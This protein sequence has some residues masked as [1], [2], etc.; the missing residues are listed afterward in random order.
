M[1][2]IARAGGLFSFLLKLFFFQLGCMDV[3]MLLC[4]SFFAPS[5]SLGVGFDF[6]CALHFVPPP[7]PPSSLPRG[8]SINSPRPSL[9][10]R[11]RMAAIWSQSNVL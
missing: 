4:M 8:V 3:C 5:I 7:P 9:A 1:A 11:M 2:M 10:M 6:V